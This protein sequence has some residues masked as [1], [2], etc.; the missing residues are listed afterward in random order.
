M[1]NIIQFIFYSIFFRP[2]FWTVK[3]K[4]I[5]VHCQGIF[6]RLSFPLFLCEK[7]MNNICSDKHTVNKKTKSNLIKLF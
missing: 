3:I 7:K 4:K 5:D 1:C 6:S 2:T